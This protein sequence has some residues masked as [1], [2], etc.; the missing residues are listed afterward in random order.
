[1]ERER[2]IKEFNNS[3]KKEREVNKK[4]MTAVLM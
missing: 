1:M 3:G 2:N 4:Q